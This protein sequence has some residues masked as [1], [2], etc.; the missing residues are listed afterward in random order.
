M[1][2]FT[3][4][5]CGL[6]KECIP[7]VGRKKDEKKAA[8]PFGAM[9]YVTSDGVSRINQQE[10]QTRRRGVVDMAFTSAGNLTGFA[11]LRTNGCVEFWEGSPTGQQ[12]FGSYRKLMSTNSL[13][14]EP[15]SDEPVRP[16]GLGYFSE[17]NRVCAGD[18]TGNISIVDSTSGKI[19]EN[20]NAY[21]STKQGNTISYTPGKNLN[22]QLATAMACDPIHGR[23]AMG[24]RERE[25][26]LLDLE[27]GKVVFKAKNLRPDPQTL[28][29]QPVWPSSILFLEKSNTMAVGTAYKQVRLYDVREDSKMRRPTATTPEGLFEYRVTALCQVDEYQLVVGDAAGYMYSLD[30]RTL[31]RNPKSAPSNNMGRY[32]GPAGS[33]RQIKKHPTLPRLAAVGLDRMLRIY[34]SNKRKQVDC[35][36]LKQRVNCV[37]FSGDDTWDTALEATIED[38]DGGSDCD[39]DQDDMVQDYVDSEDESGDSEEEKDESEDSEEEHGGTDE[40]S[41]EDADDMA[42][43]ES[44]NDSDDDHDADSSNE[45]PGPGVSDEDESEKVPADDSPGSDE[46]IVIKAPKK[47]RRR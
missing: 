12:K 19:V 33:V 25:T 31:G 32:V 5:E 43:D 26:T 8:S 28:L 41:V 18:I 23:V 39:I 24:G 29:Q 47:R 30:T 42:S 38:H 22:T 2:L 14:S 34:D 35:I 20:Y 44:T 46:E 37:I 27:T 10:T 11:A 7:E 13:F 15:T 16:L 6:L 36:Y 40:V 3:G 9:A 17:S 45:S 1:R 21:R 4:D